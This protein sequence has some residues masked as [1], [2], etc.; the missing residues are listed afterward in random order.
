[1][2]DF[3]AGLDEVDDIHQIIQPNQILPQVQEGQLTAVAG[4]YI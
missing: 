2:G 3:Q 1:V 4:G